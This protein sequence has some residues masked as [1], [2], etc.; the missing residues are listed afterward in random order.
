MILTNVLGPVLLIQ[1]ALDQL[2]RN[3]GRIVLTGSVAGVRNSPGN[4][5]SVTK[6]AVH[7]LAENVRQLVTGDGVGVTVIGPGKVDTPFWDPRGGVP[8]GAAL[9]SGQ[10]ADIVLF[11]LGQPSTVDVNQII[12]RPVGQAN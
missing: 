5:Y 4:L 7:A 8:D 6:W 3:R 2:K 9:T 10:V 12:V 11:A 1:A